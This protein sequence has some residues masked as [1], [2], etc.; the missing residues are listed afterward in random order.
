M[1]TEGARFCFLSVLLLEVLKLSPNQAHRTDCALD[2]KGNLHKMS[3][4]P[5]HGQ[6][7]SG[8]HRVLCVGVFL[9]L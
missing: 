9:H 1:P 7:S 6:F 2:S 8:D 3:C 5:I 4:L